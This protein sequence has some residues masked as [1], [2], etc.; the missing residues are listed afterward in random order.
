MNDDDYYYG[1]SDKNSSMHFLKDGGEMLWFTVS[2]GTAAAS[3]I[4]SHST[5]A[6][7]LF[8]FLYGLFA[9]G[10][11]KPYVLQDYLDDARVQDKTDDDNDDFPPPVFLIS[12]FAALLSAGILTPIGTST[13]TSQSASS[14][15]SP[16]SMLHVANNS[17]NDGGL[18]L[19]LTLVGFGVLVG[20]IIVGPRLVNDDRSQDTGRVYSKKQREVSTGDVIPK[21]GDEV[22]ENDNDVFLEAINERE[23]RL[24]HR[25]DQK[26]EQQVNVNDDSARR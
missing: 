4:F 19:S 11:G 3:V 22:E 23:R 12:Y 5:T 15:A 24:F 9:Y 13:L 17:G 16:L 6:A 14:L 18:V 20:S 26:L 21:N 1:N 7:L 10:L 25:W 8:C 2:L